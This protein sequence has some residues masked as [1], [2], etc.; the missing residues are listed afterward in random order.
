MSV[1]R[2]RHNP[3]ESTCINYVSNI[4]TKNS[5]ACIITLYFGLPLLIALLGGSKV[6]CDVIHITGF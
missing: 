3:L 6:G 1:I 2:H 5:M 4:F